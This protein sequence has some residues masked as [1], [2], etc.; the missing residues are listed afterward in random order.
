MPVAWQKLYGTA[1]WQRLRAHQLQQHPLCRFCLDKGIVTP[2]TVADHVEPHDGD[3]TRFYT[4]ALMSLCA[5]CHNSRK[6]FMEINGYAP[7][8]SLSGW[9]SDPLHPSNRVK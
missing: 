3:V 8:I 7:D 6:K 5:H 9:P 2:A 4:G 1:R